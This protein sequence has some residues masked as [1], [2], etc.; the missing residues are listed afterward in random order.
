MA[1]LEVVQRVTQSLAAVVVAAVAEIV[2]N[3]VVAAAV[4]TVSVAAYHR[5][6]HQILQLLPPSPDLPVVGIAFVAVAALQVQSLASRPW[7][8]SVK[9]LQEVPIVIGQ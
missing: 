9:Y 4:D 2:D 1:V 3:T 7:K 6:D 5:L 8:A